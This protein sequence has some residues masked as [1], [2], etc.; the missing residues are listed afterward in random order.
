[1]L[2]N[3]KQTFLSVWALI[4]TINPRK[5]T[6][7]NPSLDM[8]DIFNG[9]IEEFPIFRINKE[10]F[11]LNLRKLKILK[12]PEKNKNNLNGKKRKTNDSSAVDL[13]AGLGGN[14]QNKQSK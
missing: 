13:K 3:K 6:I 1:M 12:Y 10:N 8:N 5:R 11:G 9:K 7:L 4:K 14:N 2:Q